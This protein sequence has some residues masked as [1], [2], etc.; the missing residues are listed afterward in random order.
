MNIWSCLEQATVF[1]K[2]PD[3]H[4]LG[5]WNTVVQAVP[6][7]DGFAWPVSLATH[8]QCHLPNI[9]LQYWIIPPSLFPPSVAETD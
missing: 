2:F 7:A 9:P 4:T 1:A 6:L 3:H 8:V 5:L